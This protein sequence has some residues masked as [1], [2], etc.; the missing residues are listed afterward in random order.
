MTMDE[1]FEGTGVKRYTL[2]YME[3]PWETGVYPSSP[4]YDTV[5]EARA[6]LAAMP[7][8]DSY[9]IVERIPSL[10]YVPVG[11]G[12]KGKLLDNFLS[13]VSSKRYKLQRFN[14][15]IWLYCNDRQFDTLEDAR[16][17]A[18]QGADGT[19]QVLEADLYIRYRPVEGE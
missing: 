5:E 6:A 10:R 8:A 4:K 15:S 14:G 18:E 2:Q 1:I 12:Y 13:G 7:D 11:K 9:Q 17:A 16:A 3:K 19:Y